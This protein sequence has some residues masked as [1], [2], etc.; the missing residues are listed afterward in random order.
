VVLRAV[1]VPDDDAVVV[2]AAGE[3]R[4][5]RPQEVGHRTGVVVLGARLSPSIHTDGV[6]A[7]ELTLGRALQRSAGAGERVLAEDTVRVTERLQ[8]VRLRR[9]EEPRV[10]AP[11]R[12]R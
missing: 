6:V 4:R 11:E 1:R 12:F 10:V 8:C 9:R 2:A 5:Q 7:G 3:P